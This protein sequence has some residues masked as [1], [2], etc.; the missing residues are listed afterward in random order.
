[1]ADLRKMF[2]SIGFKG[3][4]S[5]IKKMD[6]AADQMK[7]NVGS[8]MKTMESS[9]GSAAR[10]IR[11]EAAAMAIAFKSKASSMA[12]SMKQ[13]FTEM[14]QKANTSIEKIKNYL[15]DMDS[16]A[17]KAASGV[18]SIATALG[19]V[20]LVGAGISIVKNSISSAFDRIDT[21]AQFNRTLTAITG[22]SESVG[23]ALETLKG[24]T[25]GTA[26]GLDVA[27]QATQNFVTRGMGVEEATKSV[28]AWADA[29]S[30]YG[31]GTNDELATVAD[32]I[33]QMRTKGTVEMDQLNR[34]FDVGIDAVGMYAKS[35]GM[36]SG[37]VQEAL[38]K[39]EISAADFLS[40]VENAMMTGSNGVQNVAGAAKEAG[41]SWRGTFDNMGAAATRG[42]VKIIESIDDALTSNG[43]PTLKEL[44]KEVGAK[45]EEIA[46]KVA[47][48][49]PKVAGFIK[50]VY[51]KLQP[52]MPVI[53]G[54]TTA[55]AVYQGVMLALKGV[56]LIAT[57]VQW[58][59]NAAMTANPIG[60]I[61]MAVIG[62]IAAIA[63]LWN[64]NEGFRNAVIGIW[65]AVSG[66]LIQ[67]WNN[68]VSGLQ[69]AWQSLTT[70]WAGIVA[71]FQAAVTGIQTAWGVVV[72]FFQGVWAG[73]VAVFSAVVGFYVGIFT[74]AWNGI[75]TAW[76]AV[77]GFFSGI[78]SGIQGAFSGISGVIT[79]AFDGAMTFMSELPGKFLQWGGDMINGLIEGIKSKITGA[80]DAIK[81][82]ATSVSDA[83]TQ[84]FQIKSPS[85]LMRKLAG[86]LPE[87]MALGVL[88]K[89]NLV[90]SAMST[91]MAEM[92]S[93]VQGEIVNT[94][95][96]ANTETSRTT[97]S[98]ETTPRGNARY[99]GN[100][101]PITFKTEIHITVGNGAD[102]NEIVDSAADAWETKMERY[103]KKLNLRNPPVTA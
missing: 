59:L 100:S 62:L 48:S 101:A 93:P 28:G 11:S 41:S 20:A 22:N 25:K 99:S 83:F 39:G 86:Y 77:V 95:N 33:G 26:Y 15:K 91:L 8:S 49:M 42:M 45:F 56:M 88:D 71:G 96:D 1:M 38:S 63:Y 92:R 23:Q 80:V 85:H 102:V 76:G 98:L 70:I 18:K 68:I 58:A 3:D 24:I 14:G 5:G 54:I 51:D 50:D 36:S 47:E 53:V 7:K 29:V 82:V 87:G 9:A 61:V 2:F 10:G 64:T 44:I 37:D 78:V 35:M 84:F 16:G 67:L 17:K 60:I 69:Q 43:L 81:G 74:D 4:D 103:I 21:M 46:G 73:I 19:L 27:A 13:S 55:F 94:V 65:M 97:A 72:G 34:L 90:K 30:F 52:F 6:S 57:G 32:A 40:T 79:G 12:S 89:I 31:K 66:F 75:Q